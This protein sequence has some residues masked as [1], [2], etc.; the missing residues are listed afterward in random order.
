MKFSGFDTRSSVI[1]LKN[2]EELNAMF[3]FAIEMADDLSSEERRNIFG[4]FHSNPKKLRM[5]PGLKDSFFSFIRLVEG[6]PAIE[7]PLKDSSKRKLSLGSQEKDNRTTQKTAK[8]NK[9]IAVKQTVADVKS[10]MEKW[11]SKNAEEEVSF[12]LSATINKPNCMAYKCLLCDWR[13]DIHSDKG[14]RYCLSNANKHYKRL[15][16]DKTSSQC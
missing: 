1:R 10:R 11:L 8:I 14:G 16:K 15:N 5:L 7:T 4:V 3:Q 2:P 6:K 13:T 12:E 9:I